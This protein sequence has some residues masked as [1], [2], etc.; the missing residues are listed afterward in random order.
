M[1]LI[2]FMWLLLLFSLLVWHLLL[3]TLNPQECHCQLLLNE[4]KCGHLCRGID[5]VEFG[6]NV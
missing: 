5:F 4:I 6:W 3:V 1:I 2:P